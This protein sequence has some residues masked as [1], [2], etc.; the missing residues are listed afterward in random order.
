MPNVNYLRGR[1]FEYEI[2]KAWVA[3]GHSVMRT[4]GSHG[5][6][7]LVAIRNDG[8]TLIQC[9]SVRSVAQAERLLRQW[10]LNPPLTPSSKFHQMMVVK[11]YR[12]KVLKSV[13][14]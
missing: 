10:S 4:A 13:T 2:M 8:I 6:F 1:A 5:L 7:D 9:K 11:V 14:V 12:Q 3:T